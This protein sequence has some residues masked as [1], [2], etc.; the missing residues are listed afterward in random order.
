MET[1]TAPAGSNFAESHHIETDITCKIIDTANLNSINSDSIEF[2]DLSV[3]NLGR[4]L[5][6][7]YETGFNS[8]IGGSNS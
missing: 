2:Y 3:E 4:V 1:V 8:Q 5:L 7:A 6:T